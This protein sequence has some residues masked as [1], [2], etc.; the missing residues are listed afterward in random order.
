VIA[1]AGQAARRAEIRR[2]AERSLRSRKAAGSVAVALCW[3]AIA[4]AAVPIVSILTYTV[5]QG[6]KAW[7]LDFFTQLPTPAGIPGGGIANAILGSLIIDGL[8][9]L[10]AI[11]VGVVIGFFLAELRGG[12]ADSVRFGA[13]VL[14]GVPSIAIG[15]FAYALLVATLGHFSALSASF[16]L[17]VLM[18]PIVVR[19]AE[20][21]IRTVSREIWEGGAALGITRGLVAFRIVLPAALPGVVTVCLLAI[22]RAVGESAPLLFTTIGNQFF[23]LSPAQPMA[24]MPL[25]IYLDGIQAYPDLQRTAWGTALLL[26][27]LVLVLSLASRW[28]AG[29]LGGKRA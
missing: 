29:R 27:V 4:L 23:A 18:L 12:F 9:A 13:D 19:G 20:S 3:L 10:V 2:T 22:A 15:L 8:A 11:P 17:A 21:A 5:G 25:V 7:D 6:F 1:D 24:S 14:A 16:A 26:L 28:V